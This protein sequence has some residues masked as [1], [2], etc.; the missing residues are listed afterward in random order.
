[1]FKYEIDKVWVQFRGLPKDLRE[2]PIIWDIDSS[3]GV[4]H[5]VD[6]KFT[7]KF[8]RA[9]MK[10]AVL[11]PQLIPNLVD[12]VSLGILFT[13]CNFVLKQHCPWVSR[14]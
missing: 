14:R 9:R 1:V 7:K 8:G 10:V 11:D 5:A 12:V 6:T 3:S 2:F 13:S 4:P